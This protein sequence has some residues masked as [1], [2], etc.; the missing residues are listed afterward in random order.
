VWQRRVARGRPLPGAAVVAV[1]GERWAGTACGDVCL[2]NG[3]RFPWLSSNFLKEKIMLLEAGRAKYGALV[4]HVRAST[5]KGSLLRWD[6]FVP[7][8]AKCATSARK[9]LRPWAKS[10]KKFYALPV[11]LNF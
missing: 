3:S 10:F 2:L 9:K 1:R 5:G 8:H 4:L 11:T 6:P 7:L